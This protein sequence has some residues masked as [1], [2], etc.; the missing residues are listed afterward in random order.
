MQLCGRGHKRMLRNNRNPATGRKLSHIDD[1]DA[2]PLAVE[3]RGGAEPE[4]QGSAD[5]DSE[6]LE[7]RDAGDQ[8]VGWK[9]ETHGQNLIPKSRYGCRCGYIDATGKAAH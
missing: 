2:C 1:A 8:S 9:H 5:I 6:Q 7:R 4:W 3:P